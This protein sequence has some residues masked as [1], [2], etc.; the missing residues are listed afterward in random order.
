MRVGHRN[1]GV[2]EGRNL[3]KYRVGHW[4][5]GVHGGRNLERYR[6]GVRRR[7]RGVGRRLRSGSRRPHGRTSTP[8]V[9][10]HVAVGLVAAGLRAEVPAPLAGASGLRVGAALAEVEREAGKQ[11]RPRFSGCCGK[12]SGCLAELRTSGI[13]IFLVGEAWSLTERSLSLTAA[14]SERAFFFELRA[15]D[16]ERSRL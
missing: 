15:G 7:R 9:V 3:E 6:Y 11:E 5:T 16:E 2:H 13:F 14:V 8:G 10:L 12:M 4:G 1:T